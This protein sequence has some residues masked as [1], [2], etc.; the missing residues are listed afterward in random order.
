ME[1][2][3]LERL[4]GAPDK[5]FEALT[6]AIVSRRYG[7][8]GTLRERRNQPGVEFYLK[9]EH[10]GP[11]G[12]PGR[13]WGWSCK[14][15]IL[16]DRNELTFGQRDKIK[17]SVAKAIKYVEGLTDF[18]LCLPQRPAKKDEEWIAG[19][20]QGISVRPWSGENFEAE[21]AG[22]DELRSTF[23]GELILSPDVLARAHERSVAPVKARWM[24]QVHTAS[25]AESQISRALLRKDA[26]GWLQERA[27][28]IGSHTGALRDFLASIDDEDIRTLAG[29]VAEDLDSFGAG[30][31]AIIDAGRGSRPAEARDLIAGL[32]PPATSP[33][34]LRFLVRE[35]R[36]RR[37][38]AALAVGSL[39][40]EIRDTVRWLQEVHAVLQVPLIAVVAA[41]G[42][43]KTHLAAHLTAPEGQPTAGIF[44][45]GAHLRA[46]GSLDDLA[47]RVP[48][49][50]AGNFEDLLEALN[51]AGIRA[52]ARIPLVIDGLNEAERPSEWRGLL[53]ELVPALASYPYVL[54]VVTLREELAARA[55]PGAAAT[56]RI[57]WSRPEVISVTRAY[58]TYYKIDA[59]GA[60][61]PIGMFH[62]PLLVR[63]FC[64]AANPLREKVVGMEKLPTSMVGV[65][66]RY[67]RTVTERLAEE[68][69]RVHVPADQIRRR[70]ATFAMEMWNRGVRRLPSDDARAILD[71]GETSWDESLFRRLVEE[72][73]LLRDEVVGSDD[74]ETGVLFDRFAGY[75]TADAILVRM[76]YSDAE[77]QLAEVSLWESLLGQ[78]H[79]PLGEDITIGL[80]SL[81]P[82]RFAG[83]HLWRSAPAEHRSWVLDQELDAE[84]EYLDDQ[85]I[86][87][88]AALVA[89]WDK[90]AS[91][92]RRFGQRH[93]F[94]RLWE[95]RSAPAHRLNAAFLD[96]V[97]RML[98]LAER[99]RRWTEWIRCRADELITVGLRQLTEYWASV[100]E[101][102][103]DDDLDALAVAWLLT[104]TSHSVRDL[105]TKA[106]QR[107]GRP[108]PRRLFDLASR[109]LGADDPYVVERIAGAA[110][111]AAAAR[112]LPDPGGAFEHALAGWLS[113]LRDHFL[114]GGS[115]R[116]SHELLRSYVR[117]TFE[118]AGTLHPEAVPAGIDPFA[119]TFAVVPTAPVMADD[120]PDA[121]ECDRTF[122]M[123][124]ENY[125]IGS[126]IKGRGNYDSDHPG[127]RRA[128]GEVMAR[129][130][131]LGWR[132]QVLGSIDREIAEDAAR[133]HGRERA[134]AERYGKKYGWIAYYELVGRL[135]DAGESR[136]LWAGGGRNV[137]PDIDPTFPD[138]PPAAL[139]RLPEWAPAGTIDNKAW[140]RTGTVSV[141]AGL[142]SPSEI[143]GVTGGWLLAEGF[144]EHQRD[145]RQV[146]GFFRTLLLDPEDAD[147]AAGLIREQEYPGND[148][149]PG[150]PMVR[151]VF[152]GEMPWS[153]RFEV[154]PDV[155]DSYPHRVL[156]REWGDEG[157]AFAQVAVEFPVG[158]FESPAALEGSYD[159]PSFEF[160][161]RSGLR[162]LP[163]SLDLVSLDGTRASAAFR[164]EGAWRGHLLFLRHDLVTAFADGR[165]IVQVAWGERNVTAD[166]NSIP[167]WARTAYQAYEHIWREV[168]VLDE[169]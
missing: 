79:H 160:A 141:P 49:V 56:V 63:M 72:G 34:K 124:F 99:D 113:Q 154:R 82:R 109:M 38:P 128:R 94:D 9:V 161:A 54:M 157:I 129:V 70:L 126:A 122:G 140:L 75:L 169:P 48:G 71:A 23:F 131:D 32:D 146:F 52:G 133:R 137:L 117:A 104:S 19:L 26:F 132:D 100:P 64:E 3:E 68:P 81:L 105:A 58:F 93:P 33:R 92:F 18:V 135:S 120:D 145:G 147:A 125:V 78:S 84:S 95:V 110:F 90:N 106:L 77:D 8:L 144:L 20:G 28:A 139:V 96:R 80:T 60:W 6:R 12:D 24:P 87:E 14:W 10:A 45:Q 11:L 134:K 116:S 73:V 162:L 153:P 41:A 42:Q 46:G 47:R 88:L 164:A 2:T 158:E 4:P 163:G 108:E 127:Y 40:A 89:S 151:G 142:W 69:S 130:W 29:D 53:S 74:T 22:F 155:E 59:A 97:L 152:A 76:T 101:R 17:D 107:Y 21:L 44:I 50:K 86:D 119:L 27:D 65:F 55:V 67:R 102:A 37:L 98:P 123:D 112:Q 13:V 36:M 168:R 85:T 159:V 1:L 43:G 51:S 150:L 165:R 15:F 31:R 111:G 115:A 83:L 25:Q 166:W 62:N 5:N 167:A 156:H 16:N 121:A 136:D 143:Y 30:L 57:D 138:E 7:A 149:V 66:E 39:G 118:L 103:E 91:P 61:L 35:L 148:F 114:D